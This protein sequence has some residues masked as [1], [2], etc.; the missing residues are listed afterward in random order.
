MADPTL[1]TP[2]RS[3]ASFRIDLVFARAFSVLFAS[4]PRYCLLSAIPALPELLVLLKAETITSL[5]A[6]RHILVGG[7]ILL[8]AAA[9]LVL[10]IVWLLV[11]LVVKVVTLYAAFQDMR[12]LP[13]RIGP[14][15]SR[16]VA[17]IWP[18]I[19]L[20]I[21][22]G[23]AVVFALLLLIVPGLMLV[24]MWWVAL[25]A[26]VVERLGPIASLKR[27][28]ALTRGHRWPVF[29]LS[30]VITVAITLGG[31]M[32]KVM[33]LLIGGAAV[34]AICGFLWQ[35]LVTAFGAIAVRVALDGVDTGKIAAVFD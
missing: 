27:S 30:L 21:L 6:T 32:T 34:S 11:F 4:F 1:S 12:G 10:G 20:S 33:A 5:T 25:P 8:F 24:S 15:L 22:G 14:A 35:V 3:S 26:C 28:A 13:F 2:T 31:A 16:G 19:G 29:A 9:V 17:S 7:N 23:L 18:I